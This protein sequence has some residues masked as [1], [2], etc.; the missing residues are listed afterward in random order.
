MLYG[1]SNDND[2]DDDD[3][4]DGGD[5]DDDDD[6]GDG[7]GDDDELV[8]GQARTRSVQLSKVLAVATTLFTTTYLKPL[9]SCYKTCR[10][11]WSNSRNVF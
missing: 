10:V 4:G 1:G 5:D 2:D 9:S 8:D 3:D 7:D 11:V 6:D